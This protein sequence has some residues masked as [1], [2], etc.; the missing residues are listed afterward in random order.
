MRLSAAL[1]FTPPVSSGERYQ[2]KRMG[3][4]RALKEERRTSG[5]G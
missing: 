1:R 4:S 5:R 2:V 3:P